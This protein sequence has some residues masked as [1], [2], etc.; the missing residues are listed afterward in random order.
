MKQIQYENIFPVWEKICSRFEEK[1]FIQ[2]LKDD[3][4][5]YM[6]F[7]KIDQVTLHRKNSASW[8]SVKNIMQ[9]EST[10][11]VQSLNELAEI[12]LNLLKSALA[13]R[14]WSF[15][16][17]MGLIVIFVSVSSVLLNQTLS[18]E[19]FGELILFLSLFLLLF[20]LLTLMVFLSFIVW[21]SRQR[22]LEICNVIQIELDQRRNT[23]REDF[24]E[25]YPTSK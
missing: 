1:G 11:V 24:G 4:K 20:V 13:F 19:P 2:L 10:E 6:K 3:F 16:L 17:C 15:S 18:V 21:R 8:E 23:N 7:W 14:I 25:I 22:A 5:I 12:N 9:H